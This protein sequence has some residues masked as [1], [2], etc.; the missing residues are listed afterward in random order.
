MKEN[1][2]FIQIEAINQILLMLKNEHTLVIKIE[3]EKMLF[4]LFNSVGTNINL[5]D[6]SF[7]ES[8][9]EVIPHK[10][11]LQG[12]LSHHKQNLVEIKP[13]LPIN[14]IL[15]NK[16][17]KKE[18]IPFT[19]VLWLEADGNHTFIHTIN[20]KYIIRK[21]LKSLTNGLD[22]RFQ[23]C[24]K[25]YYINLDFL[26]SIKQNSLYLQGGQFIPMSRFYQKTFT[27]QMMAYL[28]VQ[29]G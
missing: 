29:K 27:E 14:S 11:P 13:I 6:D 5:Q 16:N 19:E 9:F 20:K 26:I 7:L 3:N 25:K 12:S 1:L 28:H 17:G 18:L 24:H 15:V 21:S 2:P 22:K 4:K 23:Q 8:Q 10:L